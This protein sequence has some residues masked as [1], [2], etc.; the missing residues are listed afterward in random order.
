MAKNKIKKKKKN[1]K[2]KQ[3]NILSKSLSNKIDKAIV[4]I[5]P[6][7]INTQK[8]KTNLITNCFVS[9]STIIF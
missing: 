4:E 7:A 8:D 3:V 6:K 1:N 5:T 2:I 9:K